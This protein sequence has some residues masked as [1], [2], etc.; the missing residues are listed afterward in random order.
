[1]TQ[2]NQ[3]NRLIDSLEITGLTQDGRGVARH[4]GKTIFV[5]QAVPGDL[6][7]AKITQSQDK[8]DEADCLEILTPSNDRVEPFCE[9]Y[10]SCGGCQLQHFSLDAQRVWKGHNFMTGLTQA[11]DAKQCEIAEPLIG[12]GLGY[13]RRARLGLVISKKDK[14]ARLGFRQKSSNE[15]VDIT[16]CPVLTPAL[17]Q[18]IQENRVALLETASR[19]Y[20]EITFVEADN[21]IFINRSNDKADNNESS[22]TALP[23]YQ[24]NT[25]VNQTQTKLTFEFPKDG[26]IQVNAQ[27]NRAMVEQAIT[28]LKLEPSHKVLDLFCGVGNF[29]LPIAQQVLHAVGIEGEHAL[30]NIANHNAQ[31]NQ[32]D[33]VQFYK[34][35]LFNDMRPLP[36]FHNKQYDRILLDPGR[37]GA[38]D[39]C[40]TLGLLNAPLIVYV[41]CNAATLTRDIKELEKQGYRL[42]KA[43]LI[44]M[45]PQT[46]HTE[47]M[48]QLTK[49]Q[50]AAP[51]VRKR[52]IFK[53]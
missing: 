24:L 29:T 35:N 2:K 41:S 18:A 6:V 34:A 33:N 46:T 14:I 30:V 20:K 51:K 53:L 49:T 36:W 12:N 5:N 28:W 8:F 42:T 38:F 39:L 9:Y 52:P 7:K 25:E 27:Q 44:D 45:F 40:K 50:K 16:H 26:F 43:G 32:L 4:N 1:M 19:A 3:P 31:L 21:G 13:R 47:V 17:N 10:A 15:L 22:S 37:Q 23:Y 48:V 11:V